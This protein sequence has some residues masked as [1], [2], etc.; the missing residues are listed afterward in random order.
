[1]GCKRKEGQVYGHRCRKHRC[2]I[3]VLHIPEQGLV[4]GKLLASI[5]FWEKVAFYQYEILQH[6]IGKVNFTFP[7]VPSHRLLL[8]SPWLSNQT[9]AWT[10]HANEMTLGLIPGTCF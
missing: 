7:L 3:T 6:N 4:Q 9:P 5:V 2:R 10:L 1:M 8:Q